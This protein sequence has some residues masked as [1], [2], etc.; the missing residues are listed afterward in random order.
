MATF[1][2]N[3]FKTPVVI[4]S[5]SFNVLS[6]TGHPA[7]RLHLYRKQQQKNSVGEDTPGEDIL[8]KDL[9][10]YLDEDTKGLVEISLDEISVEMPADGVYVALEGLGSYDANDKA[11][12]NGFIPE[13]F[14]T[15]EP[16]HC[17]NYDSFK[18]SIG[19]VNN[20][21]RMARDEKAM[22]MNLSKK[23]FLAPSFGLKV[24]KP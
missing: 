14:Q 17:Y 15:Y 2:V 19:W 10:Y 4:K 11:E 9:V 18:R 6:I 24:Y 21:Q 16:I 7:Y 22:N 8:T 1:I 23:S 13:M 20:N 5:V 3:P 12:N